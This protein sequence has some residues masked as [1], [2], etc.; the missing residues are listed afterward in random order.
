MK[1]T[2]SW[3]K[4]WIECI[5]FSRISVYCT[6]SAQYI[7]CYSSVSIIFIMTLISG[8]LGI[9]YIPD[10]QCPHL[11]STE[12]NNTNLTISSQLVT[13]CTQ[14][15]NRWMFAFSLSPSCVYVFEITSF[16]GISQLTKICCFALHL[17]IIH[18]TALIHLICLLNFK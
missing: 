5:M 9:L 7:T 13:C 16:H 8:L 17:L 14:L 1:V 3:H 15:Y 2:C 4:K 12:F 10:L 11:L 6:T 18:W